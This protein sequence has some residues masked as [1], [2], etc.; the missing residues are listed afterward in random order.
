[1]H[2]LY[3]DIPIERL[4]A[5]FSVLPGY[6]APAHRPLPETTGLAIRLSPGDVGLCDPAVVFRI[7][8][9]VILVPGRTKFRNFPVFFILANIWYSVAKGEPPA[10]GKVAFEAVYLVILRKN[11][12]I[13][14]KVVIIGAS[15]FVGS[16]ILSEA[17]ERGFRVTAIVRHPEKMTVRRPELEVVSGD[18]SDRQF[19]AGAVSGSEP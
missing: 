18:V 10:A 19:L 9:P 13:M 4:L 17:L 2:D 14:K 3:G 8:R 12:M 11:G 6:L 5:P 7:G 15:G 1:M 16:A